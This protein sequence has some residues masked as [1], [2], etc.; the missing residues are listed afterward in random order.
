METRQRLHLPSSD[1]LQS[2][3]IMWPL[4]HCSKGGIVGL[5]HTCAKKR[6]RSET[7]E[8]LLK[9]RSSAKGLSSSAKGL[10]HTGHSRSLSRFSSFSK[11]SRFLPWRG[12]RA[13]RRSTSSCFLPVLDS[14]RCSSSSAS[15]AIVHFCVVGPGHVPDNWL[16]GGR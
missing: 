5:R 11:R 12:S 7:D 3:Q 16:H 8:N 4:R 6:E 2:P 14:P 15:A 13:S 10:R 9:R 1:G